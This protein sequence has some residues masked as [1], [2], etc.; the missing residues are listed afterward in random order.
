M[1]LFEESVLT[2]NC[3]AD[4]ALLESTWSDDVAN[5]PKHRPQ[6]LDRPSTTVRREW[7]RRPQEAHLAEGDR[8]RRLSVAEIALIQGFD[9]S[10]VEVPGI[11]ENDKIAALGNAVPPPISVALASAIR[12]HHRF[13]NPTL[14]EICAGIGGLSFGFHDLKPIAMIELWDVAC[15]ILRNGKPWDPRS[16]IQGKVEDYDYSAVRGKVGLLCGGPPCQ[17]WSQAG[18]QRGALDPRDVM[19]YTPKVIAECEPEV[20]LF[21]N[22]PGLVTSRQHKPY[23]DELL[24]RLAD[25]KQ[26]L[27]YGVSL[28]ILN[29]ADFGVP[30]VRRRVFIVGFK[31]RSHKF[32]SQV[33]KTVA[34]YATHHDPNK[35]AMDRKPWM[36]LREAF[37]GTS[38]S[39]PWRRYNIKASENSEFIVEVEGTTPTEIVKTP[40]VR[41]S[42]KMLK[43]EACEVDRIKFLWPGKENLVRFR[44]GKWEFEKPSEMIQK[45]SLIL[46]R[47][48]GEG[49]G[50]GGM[51][52]LGDYLDGL[53]GLSSFVQGS[54]SMVYYDSHRRD[55]LEKEVEYGYVDSIWLSLAKG[56]STAAKRCLRT[57]GFFILHTDQ[58]CSHYARMVLDEVFGREHHVTTFAWQ[59]KYGPQNDLTKTTPT[60]A[61]DYLIVYSKCHRDLIARVGL[62]APPKKMLD[63]GDFRGA[64]T[65]GHKGAKSGNEKNKFKVNI[66]PYHWK[67]IE[68]KLPK[69]KYHFDPYSGAL[70]FERV[71]ESGA[72]WIRIQAID[73]EG[74][75]AEDRIDITIREKT[76]PTE[77]FDVPKRIWW[78]LKKD[79]DIK[80]G[81]K[82]SILKDDI[83]IGLKGEQYSLIFKAVGG[84]PF[85]GKNDSPGSGRFWE[86]SLN[87]LVEAIATASAYFGT[88]G[89]SLPSI[90]HYYPRDNAL[91]M[92]AVMN[93]LPWS[94][95]GKSEDA[96]RHLRKL[97]A[98][99]LIDADVSA[100]AKPELLLYHLIRLFAPEQDD[101]VIA[102]G[103]PNASMAAVALKTGRFFAHIT[104]PS[105][106]DLSRWEKSASGRLTAVVKKLD[107][108][109]ISEPGLI[110]DHEQSEPGPIGIYS[111]SQ[112]MLEYDRLGSIIRLTDCS[113][114]ELTSDFYA[115]LIGCSRQWSKEP[116]YGGLFG[117]CAYVLNHDDILDHIL[118][119]RIADL[120]QS[121][122]RI[123]VIYERSDIA[124][125]EAVP[126]NIQI[127]HAPYELTGKIAR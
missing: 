42:I 113:N 102:L 125:S 110:D 34:R 46:K 77:K 33:L 35:P 62:M 91:K 64:F 83:P 50:K 89:M 112:M 26:G 44:N 11:K 115:G 51:V 22:V 66:P 52:V 78:L 32:A 88:R 8:Y 25:P 3:Q 24:D 45:R 105:P 84:K 72:F 18:H 6:V 74:A 109:G 55:T 65:A 61:F 127:L 98:D 76:S 114:G 12:K 30:Q 81:G 36:T 41:E 58:E 20:F 75:F 122:Q 124:E 9:P 117:R 71:E 93:W 94:E 99:G 31:D 48:M 108:G 79:N 54:A 63:D 118:L 47:I 123:Y 73:S 116:F 56:V 4:E 57:D 100:I 5:D 28:G 1:E 119:S 106:E 111:V 29:A 19:G 92:E 67:I 14:L 39:E 23:L 53:D 97:A 2:D 121:A 87:R 59:K 82:I 40:Q 27:S 90:K 95:Y 103:D 21:E 126:P 37:S 7:C 101:I 13:A 85:V 107:T 104:G 86:F 17:P 16:I 70:W 69:G 15:N 96:T 60:D 10:W 38:S 49:N 68:S 120:G 80:K 43:N